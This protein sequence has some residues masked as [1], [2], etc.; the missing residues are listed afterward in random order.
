MANSSPE[1]DH[2]VFISGTDEPSP[3]TLPTRAAGFVGVGSGLVGAALLARPD[4][5]GPLLGLT[6]RREAQA[7]GALDL[8]LAPGIL[9]GRPRWPWIAA[10]ALANVAAAALCAARAHEAPRRR[11]RNAAMVLVA[12]T[13]TDAKLV[14]DLRRQAREK[15]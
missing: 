1:T 15:L 13:A 4:E 8:A 12:L 9:F 14:A 11:G 2:T 5:V 10:R 7:V 6:R 3:V